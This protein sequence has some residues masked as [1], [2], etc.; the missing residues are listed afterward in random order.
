MLP[1]SADQRPH[2]ALVYKQIVPDVSWNHLG[3][4][5]AT[6]VP[7]GR[8]RP[9]WRAVEAREDLDALLVRTG[10]QSRRTKSRRTKSR[11]TESQ[12][13]KSGPAKSQTTKSRT[14]KSRTAKTHLS[15]GTSGS[16]AASCGGSNEP[17]LDEAPK[18]AAEA[19]H[20]RRA[21]PSLRSQTRAAEAGPRI[22]DRPGDE[23]RIAHGGCERIRL[24]VCARGP[25]ARLGLLVHAGDELMR[26][27]HLVL[28]A[29]EYHHTHVRTAARG[30]LLV[31]DEDVALGRRHHLIVK[32]D[33]TNPSTHA[34]SGV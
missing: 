32:M 14:A 10:I 7:R 17:L 19:A 3:L 25:V 23:S 2:L 20:R 28:R 22:D 24:A 8:R 13:A 33:Q 34:H 18:Q 9:I 12:P 31:E 4:S 11:R 26:M 15:T 30:R 21:S 29:D 1:A 16:S 27:H 6:S 5:D